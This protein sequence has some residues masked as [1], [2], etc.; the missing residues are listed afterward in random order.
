MG[1]GSYSRPRVTTPRSRTPWGWGN[2]EEQGE[3]Q[4]EAIFE[5]LKDAEVKKTG[6]LS[7]VPRLK[8][9][10]TRSEI[11]REI[12]TLRADDSSTLVLGMAAFLAGAEAG[13]PQSELRMT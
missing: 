12:E 11:L 10:K 3:G 8:K 4:D 6:P 1:S 7:T 5:A 2:Q 9:A 13:K